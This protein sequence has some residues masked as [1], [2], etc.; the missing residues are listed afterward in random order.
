MAYIWVFIAFEYLLKP[1]GSGGVIKPL[2]LPTDAFLPALE[3]AYH[4]GLA[5]LRSVIPSVC[6]LFIPPSAL[7]PISVTTF[8]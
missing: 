3:D 2:Q 1:L 5:R 6:K 8:E 4:A 7:Q